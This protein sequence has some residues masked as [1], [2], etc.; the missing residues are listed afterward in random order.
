[1]NGRTFWEGQQKQQYQVSEWWQL[2]H[3]Q[4]KEITKQ[5]IRDSSKET[6]PTH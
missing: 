3:N 4:Q 2:L 1:M 5:Q 6:S